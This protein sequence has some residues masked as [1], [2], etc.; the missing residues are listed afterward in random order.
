MSITFKYIVLTTLWASTSNTTC[1]KDK[2]ITHLIASLKAHASASCA[3]LTH[4]I[5]SCWTLHKTT[6]FITNNNTSSYTA[7]VLKDCCI[8]IAFN[9][10]NLRFNPS[11]SALTSLHRWQSP[12]CAAFAWSQSY[13]RVSHACIVCVVDEI[14]LFQILAL[15]ALQILHNKIL[16]F[17]MLSSLV[18]WINEKNQSNTDQQTDM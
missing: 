11:C 15:L 7:P 18:I 12:F 4:C 10:S 16:I 6:S 17:C 13:K 9:K 2:E 8:N 14:L 1:R 3:W 5:N